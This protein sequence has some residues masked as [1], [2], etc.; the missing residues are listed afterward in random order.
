MANPVKK[1]ARKFVLNTQRIIENNTGFKITYSKLKDDIDL[2][3]QQYGEESVKKRAFYNICAGGHGGFGGYFYH[4]FW[5]NID[6]EAPILLDAWTRYNP[7]RDILHDLLDKTPLPL[8]SDSAEIIQSQYTIEHID[9]EAAEV[10]F[11]EVYR[12]LKPGGV[13]KVVAPNTELDY[14]A[15]LNKDKSFYSW[16]DIQSTER[17]HPVYGYKTRLN[18]ASFEQ[19][20]LVHFAANVS[21]IHGGDNPQRIQDE[22]FKHIMNS[23]KME[24]AFDYCSSKC[25]IDIQRMYRSNHINWWNH[26]K[27]I[28]ALKAAGFSKVQIMAPGQSSAQVL[29]NHKYFDNLWNSVALFVEAVK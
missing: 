3:Q 19:L 2:Y 8:E 6:L 23:M 22:E 29:R 14:R 18:Q 15:Y 20:A 12:T 16:V 17:H 9:N 11:K 27:L 13:F 5:T 24:D 4:P 26:D 1:A 28:Q 7:E 21:T 10:F 25:S